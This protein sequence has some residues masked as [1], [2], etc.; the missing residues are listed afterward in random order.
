MRIRELIKSIVLTFL[1]ISSLVLTFMIWNFSPDV[2]ETYSDTN[3][4]NTKA[5]G[6]R[7][8]KDAGQVM[9][10]LQ[11][12]HV[13]GEK[14]EGAPATPY[15][16]DFSKL[17][18]KHHISKVEEFQ[19]NNGLTLNTLSDRLIIFDYPT[20]I[21]L[22]MYLNEVMNVPAKVPANFKFNRIILDIGQRQKVNVY[23]IDAERHR[24][25][26][27]RTNV[28][29]KTI[30]QYLS[31]MSSSL[32]SYT[33]ILT[34]QT[35]VN[36]ATYLYAPKEPKDLRT[37]RTIF[38][39]IDVEDLNS[40]LFD[41]TPI[42]RTT[43]SGNTTYNNN[44]GMVNY[45]ANKDTYSYTN[46]SEDEHSTRDMNVGIPRTF[47]FINKHG[48]FT[49]DF[50]LFKA[51]SDEGEMVYQMFV[52][53]RPIFDSTIRNQIKVIW[54]ERGIFEYSRGLLKT[55]VTVD[56]GEKPKVLPEAEEVRSELA[57]NGRV[58]FGKVQLMT[59]GY[60]MV[61]N[62]ASS[63]GLEI[64]RNSQFVPTWYIKYN[65]AWYEFRDGELIKP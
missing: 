54:G 40:I 56:N 30:D 5:I 34:D 43:K 50:R 24:A 21:P 51:N 36:N 18:D 60:R 58:D 22:A 49:D 44:T 61:T 39:N 32:E 11:M 26:R 35:T 10:P 31:N 48:G 29:V 46:L 45:D 41:D 3:K 38:S 12:I 7:Y 15:V 64:Q 55:N 9:T 6:M 62:N 19:N 25:I 1:V 28:S 37:Y 4:E 47:D 42:V 59:V 8:D 57:S 53:G 23:A 16:N 20:D 14:M 65:H 33:D 13:N 27:M 2:S 63:D 17:F 52:N